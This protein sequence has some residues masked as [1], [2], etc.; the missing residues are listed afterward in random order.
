MK[1][2]RER[3]GEGDGMVRRFQKADAPRVCEIFY[4]S[5]HEVASARYDRAQPDAWAPAVPNSTQWL[6]RLLAYDTFVADD[7]AGKT[8]G[9]IAMSE[10]GYID[11]LFCLPE[12]TRCGISARLYDEVE[13]IAIA[14]GLRKLTAHASLL[15]QPFFKKHGWIVD[16]HEIVERRGVEL[17]RAAMSKSLPLP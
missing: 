8:V 5:V 12:A 11:M 9:W 1:H 17:P 3:C 13:R 10:T 7:D 14:R 2:V 4:R 16:A 15:A 6:E